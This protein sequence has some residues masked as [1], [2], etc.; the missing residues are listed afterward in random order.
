MVEGDVENLFSDEK[1]LLNNLQSLV[2]KLEVT[3]DLEIELLNFSIKEKH[4]FE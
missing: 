2:I 4:D 1:D 3:N